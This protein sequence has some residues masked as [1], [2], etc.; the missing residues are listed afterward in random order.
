MGFDAFDGFFNL[1][2]GVLFLAQKA[3]GEILFVGIAASIGLVHT[4]SRTSPFAALPKAVLGHTL[5]L[6]NNVIPEF[7]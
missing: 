3:Q 2:Q 1:V 4:E 6:V 7:S 5:H